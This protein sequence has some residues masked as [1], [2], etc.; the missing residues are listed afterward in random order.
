[1]QRELSML[2]P[3]QSCFARHM[4]F[5]L[6]DVVGLWLYLWYYSNI[7]VEIRWNGS[8]GKHIKVMKGTRQGGLSSSF[9]FNVLYQG[10]V[11]KLSE[12]VGGS[13]IN[14][15]KYNVFC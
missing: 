1:M 2:C 4:G 9:L 15:V 6:V 12:A 11:N 14:G 10:I 3:S 5:C 7:S 8:L 13:R